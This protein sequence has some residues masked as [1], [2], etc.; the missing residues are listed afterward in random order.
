MPVIYLMPFDF[1]FFR[2]I[3][4]LFSIVNIGIVHCLLHIEKKLWN[5]Q[6]FSLSYAGH[7][8]R[9]LRVNDVYFTI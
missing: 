8:F 2:P 4:D 6:Q 1:L 5:K 3:I 9:S 7:S